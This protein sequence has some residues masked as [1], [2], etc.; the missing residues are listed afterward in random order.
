MYGIEENQLRSV[1]KEPHSSSLIGIHG[2]VARVPL[3]PRGP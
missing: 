3:A 1:T 2:E